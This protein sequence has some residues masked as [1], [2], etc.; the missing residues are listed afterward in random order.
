MAFGA[1]GTPIWFGLAPLQL[2]EETIAS[3][4]MKASL[5]QFCAA[6]FVVPVGL[7]FLFHFRALA[8]NFGFI[9]VAI[10]SASVPM[11]LMASFVSSDFA[12][13]VGGATSLIVVSLLA[14]CSP[15]NTK[16]LRWFTLSPIDDQDI[17]SIARLAPEDNNNNNNNNNDNNNSDS[18]MPL[19]PATGADVSISMH[20]ALSIDEEQSELE[21]F[22]QQQ[23]QHHQHHHQQQQHQHSESISDI[24]NLDLLNNNNNHNDR[25]S[26][27]RVLFAF[28]PIFSII[29]LLI[30]TR[31]DVLGIKALL[32]A[33]EPNFSFQMGTLGKFRLSAALVV[34]LENIFGSSA[35]WSHQILYVPS[36]IPFVVVVVVLL[37]VRRAS[38]AMWGEV[39]GGAARRLRRPALALGGA[40]VLVRL[41]MVGGSEASVV[42]IGHS[43]GDVFGAA[44]PPFAFAL[45]ALGSFFSGSATVS[46]LT[47][48]SVQ[49]EIA[50]SND[51]DVS[52]I[53]ALQTA[54]AAFGNCVCVHNIVAGMAV[55]HLKGIE[56]GILKRTI[57]PLL[58]SFVI[59]AIMS[60]FV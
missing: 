34:S 27:R 50:L 6:L 38:K 18:L 12:S 11:V 20:S 41:L 2:D 3:V 52:R 23:R 32:T 13:V 17:R 47:F 26:K 31:I 55:L 29:F 54:G 9:L 35:T 43:F 58:V 42:I 49:R 37:L 1:V 46:N 24:N 51:L 4:A 40:L 14:S 16:L 22:E 36:V 57:A 8:R 53:I 19:L 5:V 30:V 7:S 10:L 60:A 59:A 48:G 56:A 28:L 44:W 39:F 45:G 33:T 25:L 21:L 15:S